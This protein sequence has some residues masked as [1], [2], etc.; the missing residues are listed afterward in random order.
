L[1]HDRDVFARTPLAELVDGTTRQVGGAGQL[2]R[3][4]A[5][6]PRSRR[7]TLARRRGLRTDVITCGGASDRIHTPHPAAYSIPASSWRHSPPGRRIPCP[8][9]GPSPRPLVGV[10]SPTPT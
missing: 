1:A 3:H 10:R 9:P 2:R 6:R 8:Y 4:R 5:P 7:R